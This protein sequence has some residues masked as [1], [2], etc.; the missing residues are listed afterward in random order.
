MLPISPSQGSSIPA[1]AL[2]PV[3]HIRDLATSNLPPLR[4][5][6][7]VW[8]WRPGPDLSP[9]VSGVGLEGGPASPLSLPNT[10]GPSLLQG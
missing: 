5:D 1:V 10:K 4:K 8:G 3:L 2:P 7:G 9:R 6:N